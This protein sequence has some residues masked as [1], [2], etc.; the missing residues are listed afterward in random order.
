MQLLAALSPEEIDKL[1]RSVADKVDAEEEQ[2]DDEE[3]EE[4]DKEESEEDDNEEEEEEEEPMPVKQ[5]QA[6]PMDAFPRSV[7]P[8]SSTRA[9]SLPRSTALSWPCQ[10]TG[11]LSL[12]AFDVFREVQDAEDLVD[13]LKRIADTPPSSPMT[14]TRT[15]R[16]TK[17]GRKGGREGGQGRPG[18]RGR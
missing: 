13:S 5:A 14:R 16:R 18:A 9:S 8:N 3:S 12:A 7:P 1:I 6:N 4:D 15:G 2:G 17:G 11:I 10:R